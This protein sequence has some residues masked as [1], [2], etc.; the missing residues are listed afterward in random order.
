MRSTR[1]IL[2]FRLTND[3]VFTSHYSGNSQFIPALIQGRGFLGY[4]SVKAALKEMHRQ[5]GDLKTKKRIATQGLIVRHLILPEN[6]AGT[7]KI[8][9]FISQKT[10]LNTYVNL[11]SQYY[12]AYKARKYEAL[13]RRIRKQEFKNNIEIAEKYGLTRGL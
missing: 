10:S 5:V 3:V 11:M 7:E 8:L 6:K 9:K 4:N 2:I 12:P 13:Q 1:I